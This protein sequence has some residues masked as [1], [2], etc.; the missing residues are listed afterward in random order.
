MRSSAVSPLSS[1][2]RTWPARFDLA[3]VEGDL[4]GFPLTASAC[5]WVVAFVCGVGLVD[6][7]SV[8]GMTVILCLVDGCAGPRCGA[9]IDAQRVRRC[10]ACPRRPV[11]RFMSGRR[12]P[13]APRRR[14]VHSGPR[15]RQ[16][17]VR[18]RA[19]R[20]L[21]RV[22]HGTARVECGRCLARCTVDRLV[23]GSRCGLEC[24]LAPRRGGFP[25]GCRAGRLLGGGTAPVGSDDSGPSPDGSA[26]ETHRQTASS[27]T[28]SGSAG[29]SLRGGA[30]SASRSAAP[31]ASRSS[32][33]R[34]IAI[35]SAGSPNSLLRSSKILR[36]ASPMGPSGSDPSPG[37]YGSP[38][39]RPPC[40]WL[41]PTLVARAWPCRLVPGAAA[42]V[43]PAGSTY[44]QVVLFAV[45]DRHASGRV[46]HR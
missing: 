18:N 46:R 45:G 31:S 16:F 38:S 20:C 22:G 43:R 21:G 2:A 34:Q 28:S 12:M 32:S 14:C 27:S 15:H 30:A 33:S 7:R 37:S 35:M 6:G 11:C 10:L 9:R 41:W 5:R 40:P 1:C 29:S 25:V 13:P 8:V 26:A 17:R 36:T 19:R 24:R 44:A 39:I 3:G 23:R 42:R 4:C